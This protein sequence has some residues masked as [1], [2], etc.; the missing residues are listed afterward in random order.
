MKRF[1]K[2]I[3][4]L[5][6]TPNPRERRNE[7]SKEVVR[8]A[9]YLPKTLT[10]EDIDRAF[11]T[12]VEERVS[13]VQDGISLPT[14][15]LYSNQRFSEYMQTWK[16][17]DENNNVRLNFKTVTRETNPSHGTIMGDTYNIPGNRFYTL[18]SVRA[19]DESG[20][21]YRLDYKIKQPTPVDLN[22]KVSIMTNK[23][24]TINDFNEVINRIFNAKQEYICPNG[25][26]ISIILEQI[27][28]ESE[29]NIEDRQFF[30]QTVTLKV[31]GYIIKEEDFRIEE[32]PIAAVICFE[33]DNDKRN[34]PYVEL[35]EYDPCFVPE[36]EYYQKQVDID[37]DLTFCNPYKGKTKFTIDED[38]ILT[39]FTFK[40]PNN[41]EPN[42]V[43]LFVNDI[44]ISENLVA[45][46]FEGYKKCD[47]VPDDIDDENMISYPS[48]PTKKDKLHKYVLY[49]GEYYVWHQIHFKEGDDIII[50]TQKI[51]RYTHLGAFT[52][53]GYNR[54]VLYQTQNNEV[55]DK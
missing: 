23:Y 20:K 31:R 4:D 26:Y 44:L 34:K 42:T 16:Y 3:I 39:S 7:I 22:Y 32:N 45:D 14:M 25:H 9:D 53:H 48:L 40:E 1:Y 15:V 43:K 49:Q 13:I 30:S 47:T 41:I 27:S 33:G 21:E 29:Y 24:T 46:A 17:T 6:Y 10:Y 11:K 55:I 37:V 28:D 2:N 51:K 8:H 38:F 12:W 5:S 52:L 54:F 18:K 36:E 50:Q 19:V 35:S